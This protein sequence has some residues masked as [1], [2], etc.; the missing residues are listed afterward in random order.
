MGSRTSSRSG[1]GRSSGTRGARPQS[2]SPRCW[3][4]HAVAER[5]RVTVAG[6]LNS[7]P[8]A[9]WAAAAGAAAA[10]DGRVAVVRWGLDLDRFAPG[11][12][13]EAREAL[14]LPRDGPLVAGVRGLRALYNPE[15]Q[16]EA[17]A[18]VRAARP[19]ARFLLKHP[20]T[21]T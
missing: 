9:A 12:A 1:R 11:S 21:A 20:L 18:R 7:P 6:W 4:R 14:G 3:M 8:V 19:R 17:F 10:R 5:L 16:L 15:L 2:A 13:V